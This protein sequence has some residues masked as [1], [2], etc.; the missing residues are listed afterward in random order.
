MKEGESD[1]KVMLNWAKPNVAVVR[2]MKPTKRA[3]CMV[4]FMIPFLLTGVSFFVLYYEIIMP[5][6]CPRENILYPYDF[7]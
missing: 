1:Q 3:V 6:Q 7:T 5:K 4:F 2:T